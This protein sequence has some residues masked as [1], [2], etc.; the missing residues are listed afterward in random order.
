MKIAKLAEN[1]QNGKIC[2]SGEESSK[3]QKVTKV[4]DLRMGT[5]HIRSIRSA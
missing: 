5:L 2:Q 1:Q 4:G 3:W